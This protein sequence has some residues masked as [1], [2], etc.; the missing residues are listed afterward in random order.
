MIS[1]VIC[2]FKSEVTHSV[3]WILMREARMIH[4]DDFRS[5]RDSCEGKDIENWVL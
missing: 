5:S 4:V 3:V 1:T 2:W